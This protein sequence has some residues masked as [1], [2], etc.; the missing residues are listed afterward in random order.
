MVWLV[1][2]LLCSCWFFLGFGLGLVCCWFVLGLVVVFLLVV[3]FMFGC[4]VVLC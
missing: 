3:L 1:W 4:V 2:W